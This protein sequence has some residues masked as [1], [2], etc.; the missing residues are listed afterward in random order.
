MI[1]VIYFLISWFK[2]RANDPLH[3]PKT[4]SVAQRKLRLM[5]SL[6]LINMAQSR[7]SVFHS[8][9]TTHSTRQIISTF[10]KK[11]KNCQIK[12]SRSFVAQTDY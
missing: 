11:K 7:R 3:K 8:N 9:T 6:S 5:H 12:L 1:I 10:K 4:A 2:Q